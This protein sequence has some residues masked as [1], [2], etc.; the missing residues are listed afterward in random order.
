[1]GGD[2]ISKSINL[3]HI[4]LDLAVG[5]G[6]ANGDLLCWLIKQKRDSLKLLHIEGYMH[7]LTPLLI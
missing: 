3:Y 6:D 2:L 4:F 1:M 5:Y 7:I